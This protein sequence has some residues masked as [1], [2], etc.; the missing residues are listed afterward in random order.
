MNTSETV[1]EKKS[2]S[3]DQW[4]EINK[5]ATIGRISDQIAELLHAAPEL[6]FDS[7]FDFLHGL[8]IRK[9]KTKTTR[10]T[11]NTLTEGLEEMLN[12][13]SNR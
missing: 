8:T 10:K 4:N 13:W 1:K 6:E 12:D 9:L 5:L 7:L 3:T 2:I 11:P